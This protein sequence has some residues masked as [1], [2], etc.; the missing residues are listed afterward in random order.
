MMLGDTKFYI[1]RKDIIYT[2][3]SVTS[4]IF[5]VFESPSKITLVSS[6]ERT[7]TLNKLC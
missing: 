5:T 6:F 3:I 7:F 4:I 1:D 2:S